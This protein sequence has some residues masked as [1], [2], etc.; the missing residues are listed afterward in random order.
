MNWLD[1]PAAAA[2][3]RALLHF[4]WEGAVIA[5]LL[6]VMLFALRR[7]S[8][9]ARYLAAC[10]AMAAMVASFAVTALGPGPAGARTAV[11][12]P[13]APFLPAPPAP[14]PDGPV[15]QPLE[16]WA[17][18]LWMAGAALFLARRGGGWI[19]ARRM[20]NRGVVAADGR[21]RAL[22]LRLGDR[23]G[24]RRAVTMV[25]SALVDAPAVIGW[26]RPVILVPAGWLLSLPAEQ[27]EAVLLH[28]LAH[29]RRHDYLV[30]L[31]Q[32]L[33]EDLLFY[34]PAVWWV[35]RV[36]RRERENCCD[37]AVLA[38]GADPRGYALTLAALAGLSAASPAVAS[39]GG[40][41]A[42]RIRRLLLPPAG[43]RASAAP[44]LLALVLICAGAAALPA[45]QTQKEGTPAKAAPGDPYSKWVTEDVA[46]IVRDEER[47]AFRRLPTNEEK[48]HFIEQFWLRRDPTPG[49]V[50][51]EFKQEHY[52]R[53]AYANDH[54]AARIP[55]WKTDRGRIYIVY[56][57]PDQKEVHPSGDNGG[58]PS[59]QWLYK[60]I[61]GIGNNVI[62]EFVDAQR[63]GTYRM[64]SDPNEP[65]LNKPPAK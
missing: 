50:E 32:S 39:T 29:I 24:L 60:L 54:Y 42:Q 18:V 51:N 2:M 19:A 63:D 22:V 6:A 53:I 37:D 9:Q 26:L 31:L 4:V 8:S 41:L 15:P 21:G 3:A 20:L 16:T 5:A 52:R 35:G 17:V 55:G 36:M 48:E 43:P 12:A 64:T 13:L 45:F 23:I 59:E 65:A 34:H 56:G 57:P 33:V 46:Y 61:Q 1:T 25:E 11:F 40:S 49:T 10:A 58:P 30:N 7:A 27:A 38:L 28:E 47:A 62:V 44:L 14:G